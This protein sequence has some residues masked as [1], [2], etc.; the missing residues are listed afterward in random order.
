MARNGYHKAFAEF[1]ESREIRY[2]DLME[3]AEYPCLLMGL[4]GEKCKYR[5]LVPF[6]KNEESVKGHLPDF[7]PPLDLIE[8]KEI[9]TPFGTQ[10]V[11][12]MDSFWE[13]D[14][15]PVHKLLLQF[16]EWNKL[17]VVQTVGLRE[18]IP[19]ESYDSMHALCNKLNGGCY[20]KFYLDED[21]GALWCQA[22][23]PIDGPS[24]IKACFHALLDV[25]RPIDKNHDELMK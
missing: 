17:A 2:Y 16:M 4:N 8:V 5:V 22:Q 24:D 12:V 20:A 11:G 18:N 6:W 9:K 15:K 23:Q 25:L 10:R 13:D 3:K 7:V 14:D 1:L 21:E 19:S